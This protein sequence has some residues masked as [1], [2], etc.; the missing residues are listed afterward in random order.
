[1]RPNVRGERAVTVKAFFPLYPPIRFHSDAHNDLYYK[2]VDEFNKP[3]SVI[4]RGT[5]FHD[6]EKNECTGI[7]LHPDTSKTIFRTKPIRA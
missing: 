1:L 2:F 4:I 7:A 6:G 5:G 3:K